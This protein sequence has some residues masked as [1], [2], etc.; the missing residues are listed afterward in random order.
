LREFTANDWSGRCLARS[1]AT[2]SYQQKLGAVVALPLVFGAIFC[3]VFAALNQRTK[4]IVDE[5]YAVALAIEKRLQEDDPGTAVPGT[6]EAI[7]QTGEDA[8]W[9]YG[10]TLTRLYLLLAATSAAGAVLLAFTA[11]A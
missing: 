10:K 8:R 1:E 2:W 3:C 6:Y 11:P 4:T 5:C 9:T 7:R